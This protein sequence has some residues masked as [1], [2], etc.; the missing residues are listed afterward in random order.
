M[1]TFA[2]EKNWDGIRL[3]SFA[4]RFSEILCTGMGMEVELLQDRVREGLKPLI[5]VFLEA[6]LLS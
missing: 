2:P 6:Y 5:T 4:D 1:T 3:T